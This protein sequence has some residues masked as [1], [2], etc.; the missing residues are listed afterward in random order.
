MLDFVIILG[1]GVGD[2]KMETSQRILDLENTLD[3]LNTKDK[4]QFLTELYE[5]LMKGEAYDWGRDLFGIEE[6]FVRNGL[7]K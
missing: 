4:K 7:K 6:I 1:L 3:S 5:R 2:R